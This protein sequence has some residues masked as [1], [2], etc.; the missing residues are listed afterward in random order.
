M[1]QPRFHRLVPAAI[2][3]GPG[4]PSEV[5]ESG[6]DPESERDPESE[7]DAESD[8][9]AESEE[10]PDSRLE[11]A[12]ASETLEE[13]PPQPARTPAV[14]RAT[15]ARVPVSLVAMSLLLAKSGSAVRAKR[16]QVT[17][18]LVQR[19]PLRVPPFRSSERHGAI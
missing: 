17:S 19:L 14:R 9:E 7:P 13:E 4:P 16:H 1:P 5:P 6:P 2:L 8:R 10:D 3:E 15:Y 11:S 12:P 18:D